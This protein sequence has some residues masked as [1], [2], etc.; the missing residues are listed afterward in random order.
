MHVIGYVSVCTG[1]I[2]Y[3]GDHMSLIRR[4]VQRRGTSSPSHRYD[5]VIL[6]KTLVITAE[7]K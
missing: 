3:G 2:E 7:D 4:R 1:K 6:E 5:V